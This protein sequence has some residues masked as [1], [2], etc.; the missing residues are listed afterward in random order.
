[1]LPLATTG[2]GVEGTAAGVRTWA[3][4]QVAASR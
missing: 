1:M 4:R 2:R 3:V